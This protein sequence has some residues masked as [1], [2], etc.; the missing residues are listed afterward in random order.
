M[1]AAPHAGS[2]PSRRRQSLLAALAA[3]AV[4]VAACGS[5]RGIAGA[6]RGGSCGRAL[7][8]ALRQRRLPRLRGSHAAPA[9]LLWDARAG[10]YV[11]GRVRGATPLVNAGLLLTHSVAA[12]AGHDG[13]V[14]QRP[15]RAPAGAGAR[16][17]TRVHRGAGRAPAARL[18]DARA[19][20]DEGDDELGRVA[21]PRLRRGDRRRARARVEGAARARPLTRAQRARSPTASTASQ[22]R[23]YWRWPAI[24]LNQINWYALIYAADATVTGRRAA[25]R[26]AVPAPARALRRRRDART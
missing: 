13:R 9:R 6:S 18:A 8:A 16:V 17:G 24:R 23:E 26:H 7:R 25:L 2:R 22:T 14:A 3:A 11:P 10:M 19:R 5:Q 4:A 20:L 12:Q 15:P 21:A 1:R